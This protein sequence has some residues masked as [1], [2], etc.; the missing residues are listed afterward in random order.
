MLVKA[1]HVQ[2]RA[3]PAVMLTRSDEISIFGGRPTLFQTTD[4]TSKETSPQNLPL[5]PE[6]SDVVLQG[7]RGL[8]HETP[9]H[10][11][12]PSMLNDQGG[13]EGPVAGDASRLDDRWSSLMTTYEV[14]YNKQ[15]STSK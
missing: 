6:P 8:F 2:Q 1:L 14:M 5:I 15:D 10:Y 11:H 12:I 9:A 13:T 7:W 4:F 3:D